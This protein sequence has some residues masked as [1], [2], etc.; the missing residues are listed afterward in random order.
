MLRACGE[1]SIVIY[2]AFFLPM[3]ALR[4]VL[5]KSGIITDVGLVSLL[6]TLAAVAVPLGIERLVRHTPAR[7]LFRR[8]AACHLVG[9]ERPAATPPLAS[10][11]TV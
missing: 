1:R 5:V 8:P 11:R 10:A 3:A 9:E 6:V 7:F 4:I 2:L